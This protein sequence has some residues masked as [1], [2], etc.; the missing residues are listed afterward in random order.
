MPKRKLVLH[1][2]TT[3]KSKK[4]REEWNTMSRVQKRARIKQM[5]KRKSDARVEQRHPKR[6]VY[7]PLQ[8]KADSGVSS[9]GM[10]DNV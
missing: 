7:R 5:L 1:L 6:I 4:V 9:S 8:D 2:Q 10:C 3:T